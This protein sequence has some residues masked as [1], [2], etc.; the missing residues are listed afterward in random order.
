[1]N[2]QALIDSTNYEHSRKVSEISGLLAKYAGYSCVEAMVISQA[3]LYH[4]IGKC[5]ISPEILNKPGAL[6]AQEYNIVKCHTQLGRDRIQEALRVLTAASE[7]AESHHERSDGT[8]YHGLAAE[9]IHPYARLVAVADVYDALIS[10]RSYKNA[11]NISEALSYLKDR[12]GVQ[13]DKDIVTALLAH[14]D[15]IVALYC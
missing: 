3:A 5:D 7:I 11:L 2:L 15:E 8:G 12:S 6:T 14:I 1:M 4:D 13:F 9:E 10:K